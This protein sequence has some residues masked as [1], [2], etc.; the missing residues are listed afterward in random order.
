MLLL[1]FL[2]CFPFV[3][4]Q[5]TFTLVIKVVDQTEDPITGAFVQVIYMFAVN[6]APASTFP[7]QTNAS[8]FVEFTIQSIEPSANITVSWLGAQVAFQEV[9]LSPGTNFFTITCDISDVTILTLD[10]K[11]R[12]LQGA[13]VKL[14]WNEDWPPDV[15]NTRTTDNQGLVIF[16][17]M[18]YYSYP[19]SVKWQVKLVHEDTFYFTSSTTTYVAEC[20][21]YDL[22]VNVVDKED[23]PISEAD[24]GVTRSDEWKTSKKTD[25]GV[26]ALTQLATENYSVEASFLSSSNTTTINLLEDT[27]VFLKLNISVLRIF[28]VTVEVMWSDGKPVSK[29]IVTVQNNYGQQLLSD[30]T[31]VNGTL[32]I[33]LSEGAYM[34]RV[35][36]DA[37]SITKNVTVTDQTI[38]PVTFDASLR[39]HTLTV[40]VID[41]RG[42]TPNNA[43]V[44]LYQNGNLIDISETFG[45]TAVFNVKQ[46]TYKV[47]A[48]LDNKQRE[49]IIEIKDDVKLVMSFY[50][51]NPTTLP[52]IFLT[53]PMLIVASVG[54]LLFYCKRRK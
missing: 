44:E 37:L 42:L 26:A 32:T 7:K 47:I 1:I 45:G 10:S 40:E 49:R 4:S 48:K 35:V 43:V 50:E 28:D 11:G 33:T 46:Y 20:K 21:A 36:K 27:E 34:V 2:S 23:R 6:E 8:G 24:V 52:L 53:I 39:T 9:N 17:Q 12:P 31:D 38:V 41:E 13:E 14:D 22:T 29:A 25:N 18:P 5:E 19:V 16:P 3:R 15:P 30:I 51:G 54:L